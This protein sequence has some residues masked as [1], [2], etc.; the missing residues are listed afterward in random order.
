MPGLGFTQPLQVLRLLVYTAAEHGAQQFIEMIFTSSAGR[1]I[2]E[3]Y[4]ESLTLPEDIAKKHGNEDTG[5]YLEVVT[6]RCV[7]KH[8]L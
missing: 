2:F 1:V 5:K 3:T 8:V 7:T 4:K 6:K